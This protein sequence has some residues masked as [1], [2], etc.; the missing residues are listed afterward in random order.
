MASKKVTLSIPAR[1]Y[2]ALAEFAPE[3]GYKSV[4]ELMIWSAFYAVIIGKPHYITAPIAAASRDVQDIF[5]ED[6]LA[7]KERGELN[8]GAFFEHLLED[9][10]ERF[11]LPVTPEVLKAMVADMVRNRP[12]SQRGRRRPPGTLGG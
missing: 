3:A 6:F 2:D 10:I 1:I 4:P 5:V 11:K 7:A 8:H 9:M 12:K